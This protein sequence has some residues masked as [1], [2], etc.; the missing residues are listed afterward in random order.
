MVKATTASGKAKQKAGTKRT[1]SAKGKETPQTAKVE[2]ANKSTKATPVKK[3]A[4]VTKKAK[5]ARAGAKKTTTNGATKA[6]EVAKVTKAKTAT[7]AKQSA[8]SDLEPIVLDSRL[9]VQ[10]VSELKT[11]LSPYCQGDATVVIDASAVESIDTAGLQLLVA[12]A[13]AVLGQS[14]EIEWLKPSP[15]IMEIA[16]LVDLAGPLNLHAKPKKEVPKAEEKANDLL[17][18]F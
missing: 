17:P 2:P 14:R 11:V 8:A 3:T 18:V 6:K 12:F 5:T 10:D 4:R 7:K 9:L 15:A 16:E 1:S 13:N